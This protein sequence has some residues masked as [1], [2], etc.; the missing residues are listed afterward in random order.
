[1]KSLHGRMAGES[2]AVA[3]GLL[4]LAPLPPMQVSA[5]G[6]A[7]VG[8]WPGTVRHGF[9]QCMVTDMMSGWRR[10]VESAS[11]AGSL[12]RQRRD[13]AAHG[14]RGGAQARRRGRRAA[15]EE[16]EEA[17]GQAAQGLRPCKPWPAA[18][19]RALAAQ[20]AAVRLQEEEEPPRAARQQGATPQP[21]RDTR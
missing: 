17:E 13:A 3:A 18:G 11:P 6:V 9:A 5:H 12:D 1:M 8:A 16:D 20:V 19:P 2:W 21:P 10:R 7:A 4:W 15:R 14:G